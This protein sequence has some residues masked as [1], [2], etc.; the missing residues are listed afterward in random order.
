M[1]LFLTTFYSVQH[2]YTNCL[3]TCGILCCPAVHPQ[4]LKPDFLTGRYS[5]AF[6]SVLHTYPLWYSYCHTVIGLFCIYT[7]KMRWPQCIEFCFFWNINHSSVLST[8]WLGSIFEKSYIYIYIYKFINLSKMA[9]GLFLAIPWGMKKKWLWWTS[10][11]L[12]MVAYL[13]VMNH[14]SKICPCFIVFDVSVIADLRLWR[15]SNRTEVL[16]C[17]LDSDVI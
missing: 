1:C 5:L 10:Y 3:G 4:I 17:V 6:P 11:L 14:F 8:G 12:F 9:K 13:P 16:I 7:F 2:C 15:W